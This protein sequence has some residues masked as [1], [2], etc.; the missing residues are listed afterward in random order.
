[1][2]YMLEFKKISMTKTKR[3][4]VESEAGSY[5]VVCGAGALVRL[6]REIAKVGKF[7]SLHVVTSRRVWAAVGKKVLRGLGGAKAA[8]LHKLDDAESAKNLRSVESI[9]RSLV[10]AGADRGA[11]VI[12]VGGGV[13]GDVAGFAAASY[14]RGVA[15]VQV[16]TTLVAQTDSAIGGKTGVNLPEGKNL[17]GAFYPARLVM[18]DTDA[19]ATLP[20]REFRGGL[21]EVIKYGVIADAKLFAFLEKNFEKLLARDA[22]SLKYVIT[23]SVEIK[24]D[25]VGKDERESGL[26]E[27][28]N[29][30]HTF[31]HALESATAY[32]KYQHGEAV[33]WGMMAAALYGH[34]IRLTPAADAS[35]IISLIRRLGQLPA[36]PKVPAKR[37]IELMGPDK[38]TRNGKLRFV[39]TPRIG[40]ARTYDA[41]EPAK[42]GLILRVTPRMAEAEPV[43]HD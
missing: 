12:A 17:V 15:L 18:V 1:M 40:K 39:L 11:A 28:L 38:K 33:A 4:L 41:R 29:F 13:V 7:S 23:R 6:S 31:G 35:R 9:A 34:E 26:R 22:R 25:V 42:L 21:A 24:A 5:A 30:G 8:R 16:P 43:L 14:L 20:E 3:I 2:R 32:K 37:L 27:V 10:K 36:W 19:L